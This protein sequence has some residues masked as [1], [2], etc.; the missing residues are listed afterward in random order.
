MEN[1]SREE[2]VLLAARSTILLGV[3]GNGL[4]HL[5]WM[6]QANPKAT[7]IEIFVQGG[8]TRDYQVTAEA[9]GIKYYG[10]WEDRVFTAPD[11]PPVD[12]PPGFQ[13]SDITVDP[14]LV[15]RTIKERLL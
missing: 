2:Q 11:F 9:F 15:V 5:V 12:F 4:T 8:F 6:D 7:V 13:D 3:H 14:A 1:L 10:A